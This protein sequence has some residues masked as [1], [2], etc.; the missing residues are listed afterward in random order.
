MVA[1]SMPT[2]PIGTRSTNRSGWLSGSGESRMPLA[3]S[4][5]LWNLG[6]AP[7]RSAVLLHSDPDEECHR[8]EEALVSVRRDQQQGIVG[9]AYLQQ[10]GWA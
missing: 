1:G 8:R 2:R 4:R 5:P 3:R 9:R 10:A 6:A 7:L